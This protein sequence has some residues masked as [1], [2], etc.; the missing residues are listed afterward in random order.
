MDSIE[1]NFYTQGK[2]SSSITFEYIT[3]LTLQDWTTMPLM[4]NYSFSDFPAAIDPGRQLPRFWELVN[5][6]GANLTVEGDFSTFNS[7]PSSVK[8]EYNGSTGNQAT[9]ALRQT[10]E[11]RDVL[12][13]KGTYRLIFYYLS[14]D[15]SI[16]LMPVLRFL[17]AKQQ[18]VAQQ[19]FTSNVIGDS[20]GTW[21]VYDKQVTFE[22]VSA[23]VVYLQLWLMFKRLK[24]GAFQL[25][26][27]DIDFHYGFDLTRLPSFPSAI[28]QNISSVFKR[29]TEGEGIVFVTRG[30][31]IKHIGSLDFSLLPQT[32]LEQ[33]KAAF[34]FMKG[35]RLNVKSVM[36]HRAG[37]TLP[38][39]LRFMWPERFDWSPQTSSENRFNLSIPVQEI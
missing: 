23:D 1:R 24:D 10:I 35:H 32:Q 12:Q 27:D 38:D 34:A 28:P 3:D 22:N 17:N 37:V 20:A 6:F 39:E 26:L 11:I 16:Q 7:S 33:M 4:E 30:G 19:V 31:T 29:T 18:I 9:V 14:D 2:I 15:D 21:R 25:N 13:T 36:P 5:G 8:F